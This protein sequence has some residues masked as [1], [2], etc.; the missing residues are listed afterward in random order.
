MAASD[1]TP[2][3]RAGRLWLAHRVEVAERAADQLERK[4][5]I[6]SAELASQRAKADDARQQWLTATEHADRW[7]IRA[8]L[9]AGQQVLL[10]DAARPVGLNL[11]WVNT[12]GVRHPSSAHLSQPARVDG[13]VGAAAIVAAR[14]AF[15]TAVRVGV[16]LAIADA[17]CRA[18]DDARTQARRRARLLRKRWLPLLQDRLRTLELTLEQAEQEDHARLRRAVT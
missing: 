5:H 12:V 18:L 10:D 2:S 1:R 14:A 4:I 15:A 16:D 13:I 6:L 17:T 7:A 11:T 9:V 8:A 3:G